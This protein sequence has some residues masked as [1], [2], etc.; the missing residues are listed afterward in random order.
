MYKLMTIA[1]LCLFL[2]TQSGYPNSD[3]IDLTCRLTKETV[4]GQ[5]PP[6]DTSNSAL[7]LQITLG[8]NKILVAG[9]QA[10]DVKIEEELVTFKIVGEIFTVSYSLDRFTG[11]LRLRAV[12]GEARILARSRNVN[13]DGLGRSRGPVEQ[14]ETGRKT[15][16]ADKGSAAVTDRWKRSR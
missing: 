7:R 10:S 4:F 5:A 6:I 13:S 9:K 11:I 1:F 12:I 15:Q 16:H 2:T 14:L 3:N 8:E